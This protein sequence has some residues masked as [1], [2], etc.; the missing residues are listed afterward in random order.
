MFGFVGEFVFQI[1]GLLLGIVRVGDVFFVVIVID[2]LYEFG[3]YKCVM[4]FVF[5][6]G[7]L[8][9]F[10]MMNG[11]EVLIIVNVFFELGYVIFY[12]YYEFGI[13]FGVEEYMRGC[14]CLV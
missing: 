9:Y 13:E 6:L 10:F 5:G 14:G 1:V 4:I 12:F 3:Y 11:V 8:C 2:W 7:V